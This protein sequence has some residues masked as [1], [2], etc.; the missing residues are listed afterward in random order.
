MCDDGATAGSFNLTENDDDLLGPQDP[1][2]FD[3]KYYETLQDAVD[4]TNVILVPTGYFI[5]QPSPQT[6]Y[7]RVES[8][9][10]CFA[11]EEFK[12]FF[13]RV[14]AGQP[15]GIEVCDNDNDGFTA[16]DLPLTFDLDVLDGE[17][18]ADSLKSF[19]RFF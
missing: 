17:P 3:V 8:P 16:I 2:L 12:I 10:G 11:T 6:I 4:D 9:E 13:T 18:A 15:E 7:A 5:T 14:Q 1:T 19:F